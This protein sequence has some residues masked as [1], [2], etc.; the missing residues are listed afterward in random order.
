M[1]GCVCTDV[2][3]FSSVCTYGRRRRVGRSRRRGPRFEPQNATL[4]LLAHSDRSSRLLFIFHMPWG[5]GVML[6]NICR[7]L[8]GRCCQP[9]GSFWRCLL[10]SSSLCPC[11][12]ALI[13]GHHNK[14]LLSRHR[15]RL[16]SHVQWVSEKHAWSYPPPV[17][18]RSWSGSCFRGWLW[19]SR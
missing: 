16:M 14:P 8:G 12:E 6:W 2:C 10:E 7:A 1:C 19:L 3:V 13:P 9:N 15:E 18:L 17:T 5:S 4:W 11:F